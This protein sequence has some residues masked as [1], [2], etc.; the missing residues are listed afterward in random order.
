MKLALTFGALALALPL[1]TSVVL[2]Q[3]PGANKR[4]QDSKDLYMSGVNYKLPGVLVTAA[5][6]ETMKKNMLAKKA[7][8]VPINMVEMGGHQAGLSLVIRQKGQPTDPVIHDLVSEVYHVLEGSGTMMIGGDLVNP[9]RRPTS[10]GNGPGLS[11]KEVRGG[12][13]FKIS[14][15]DVLLVPAGTSH[16]FITTDDI[17]VYTVTRLD[18]TKATPLQA[19]ST[20]VPDTSNT[21]SQLR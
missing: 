11:A 19:T 5:Q 6:I 18:P 3:Q 17:V 2:A 9:T 12:Q 20:I 15:G 4:P 13:T 1:T 7:T 14:K 8:D 10:R 21:G 16:R